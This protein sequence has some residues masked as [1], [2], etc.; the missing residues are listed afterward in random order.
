MPN[1][2]I[3]NK[4]FLDDPA[5]AMSCTKKVKNRAV[6]SALVASLLAT[7]VLLTLDQ[8]TFFMR[9]LAKWHLVK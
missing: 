6:T 3:T 1:A 9:H 5:R 4:T 7:F 8:V 2:I